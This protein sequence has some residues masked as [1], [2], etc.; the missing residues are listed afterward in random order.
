MRI[1][2]LIILALMIIAG[3]A[4]NSISSRKHERSDAFANLSTS[5][6]NAVEQGRIL[7]GMSTNAVYIAWGKPSQITSNG[8]LLTWLFHEREYVEEKHITIRVGP[9]APGFPEETKTLYSRSVV[10]RSVTFD[11]GLVTEWNWTP[12]R[13]SEIF[14]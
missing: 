8:S 14:R 2:I 11:N 10:R 5:Q 6:Q 1:P 13:H 12:P 9:R 3:C 7:P 4:T